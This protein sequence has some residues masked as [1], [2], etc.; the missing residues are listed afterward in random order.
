[1]ALRKRREGIR[2]ERLSSAILQLENQ[3][4]S[5]LK[6]AEGESSRCYLPNSPKWLMLE[7]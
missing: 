2:N 3:L 7:A 4:E 5:S 1:V 6:G